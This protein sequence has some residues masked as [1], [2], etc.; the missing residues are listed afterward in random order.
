MVEKKELE[1]KIAGLP[2]KPGIYKFF[3]IEAELIYV[4]KAKNIKKRVSSYFNRNNDLDAKTKRLVSQADDVEF[5]IV[6]SEFDAF[7]LEN[8]LI[9]THKPK[10]NILLRDDKTYPYVYIS[11]ER[12][13]RI[14]STRKF[15]KE[16]GTYYGPYTS[17]KAMNTVMD[18][19][20]KLFSVRTCTYTLS[21]TN[22]ESGKYKI[23][24][25]YHIG[26]CKGPCEGLINEEEYNK[27]IEQIHQILKGNITPVKGHFLEAMRSSA[28]DLEF[29]KAQQFKEKLDLLEKFQSSSIIVSPRITNMDVVTI[30]SDNDYSLVNY[31]H[32]V[33]GTILKTKTLEVKK[34]LNESDEE[35]L[36]LSLIALQT[37]LES[38]AKDIITNLESLEDIPGYTFY[39][40]K[41]GDKHKLLNMSLK[42]ARFRLNQLK[43]EKRAKLPAHERILT[44]LQEDL[45]LKE[46]P[47]HIDCF[48]NSN[49]QGTS[50]VSA[51]VTFKNA[52]PSKAD[53]RHYNIKTVEGPNDFESMK[54]VVFRRY[55]RVKEEG[56]EMPQL[57]I[58]DGGKG[59]LSFAVQAL[60]EL[61]L[62]GKTAIVGIAKKLE[63]IFVPNDPYPV[64]IDKKSESLRLMQQLRNEAHRFAITFHRSKRDKKVI[65]SKL[66]G[67][68]GVG[69]K[70]MESLLR[71]FKTISGI[72]SASVEEISEITGLKKAKI[73]KESLGKTA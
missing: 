42:N 60:K 22:I 46:M 55:K 28:A 25:E 57:I 36:L 72:E 40:P 44:K 68:P 26:N 1:E 69:D 45:Q 10:F 67:I 50:P 52:K 4:G 17:V 29:E 12:F 32:I 24:L 70:T 9:K 62:Y 47:V 21:E 30:V 53:Y 11:K 54:E 18:L 61:D 63:E 27:N 58:I 16:W 38:T 15:N 49:I 39:S 31:L 33:N 6:D 19:I 71:K 20:R 8:N 66:T 34:K 14:I 37:D 13:P 56:G 41:I 5:T 64:F 65:T 51:M 2:E 48:D 23:C 43:E 35:V 59:Q 7:L 73:I 3:N